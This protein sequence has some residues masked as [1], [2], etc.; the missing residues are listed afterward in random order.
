MIID[1]RF[2]FCPAFS[3]QSALHV[4][5]DGTV[6]G[7]SPCVQLEHSLVVSVQGVD[8]MQVVCSPDHVA[9]LV[10]GRLFTEGIIGGA[11]DVSLLSICEHGT[12][13]R[14]VLED[15]KEP[16]F[17]KSHVEQV[18]SC[19][20]G[21]RVFNAYFADDRP[22]RPV[23]PIFWNE[24][25]VFALADLLSRDTPMHKS[26]FGTHSCFL[27]VDG[28]MRCCRE[29]LGRHN[30]FDKVIGYAL[31]EGIDLSRAVVY[32]SGRLPI[33]M[34]TKAI[35]AGV[36]VLASKAVPTD[37]TV[38]IAREYALTLVCSARPDSMTVYNDPLGCAG[39]R[40]AKAQ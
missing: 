35:R 27:S 22:L 36:P 11:E 39:R 9:E 33:D 30:A 24:E 37:R 23:E 3:R 38:E 13:A 34:V 18:P 8:T 12:R 28:E 31:M 26:T 20:T 17:G 19:C 40:M 10:L 5:R 16:D 4:S 2:R 32:T 29:D 21:N 14:V 15:G 7:D 1:D 6:S 25:W